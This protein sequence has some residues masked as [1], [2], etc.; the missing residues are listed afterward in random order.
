MAETG[1]RAAALALRAGDSDAWVR[2]LMA[3][4]DARIDLADHRL[5]VLVKLR[6]AAGDLL[7]DQLRDDIDTCLKSFK[8]S[9]TEP[10]DDS[11]CTWSENHQALSGAGEHLAATL[12]ADQR[13]AD[14]MLGRLKARAAEQRL[15]DWLDDRFRYGFSE[16]LSGTYYELDICALVLLV[17]HADEPLATRAA[18]VLDLLLLDLALHCFDGHLHAS[19]GRAYRRQKLNPENQEIC[20]IMS[21]VF[22]PGHP[23]RADQ[24]SG[25]FVDRQR[26]QVPRAIVDIAG[27]GGAHRVRVSHGRSLTE[28]IGSARSRLRQRNPH[29]TENELA[30]EA[31]RAAWGMQS[32]T[33]PEVMGETVK[34]VHRHQLWS[35]S[36]FA[37]LKPFRKVAPALAKQITKALNPVTIGMGLE[38]ADVTTFRTPHLSLSSAQHF[39]PKQFGDQQH[40]WQAALPAGIV[41]FST[42]PGSTGAKAESR[43]ATP[44]DWIGNGVN[45]DVAQSDNVALVL[46]DLRVRRGYLEGRRPELSHLHFPMPLFDETSLGDRCV[47]GRKADTFIAVLTAHP[48]EVVSEHEVLQRGLVSGWGVVLA[49]R[50]EFQ[51]FRA[52]TQAAQQWRLRLG[53]HGLE[54]DAHHVAGFGEHALDHR[55]H[56]GWDHSFVVDGVTVGSDHP[57]YD[58]EWVTMPRGG[59][60]CV[61]RSGGGEVRLDWQTGTREVID[62]W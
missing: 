43:P 35:N 14:G 25:I 16:W 46:H 39:R 13:F 23:F 33:D 6:L 40:L 11:M 52:F 44:S 30:D 53:R 26:Y 18:M 31:I 48:Y 29:A 50:S 4:L 62:R 60:Q 42:H 49:D 10:G 1:Y 2:R 28:A 54:L 12:L 8:Y 45:P 57:R 24:L 51:N 21:E 47:L 56:L 58:T 3:C 17:D 32:I 19:Q 9:F 27:Q 7:P 15:L 22:G 34:A 37:A 36:F 20:S 61:V 38:R 55:Y 41:V 59:T 5:V